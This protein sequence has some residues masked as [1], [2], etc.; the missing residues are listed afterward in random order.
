[1]GLQFDELEV[2][3]DSL[4]EN[5][6]LSD[7]EVRSNHGFLIVGIRRA[8]GTPMLNPPAATRLLAGDVVIVLGHHDDIPQLAARFC[9]RASKITYRGATMEA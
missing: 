1:M 5:K 7:I 9:S 3:A 4:L 6:A 2:A 8:D